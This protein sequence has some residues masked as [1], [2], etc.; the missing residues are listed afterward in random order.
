MSPVSVVGSSTPRSARA[1]SWGTLTRPVRT[2]AD[3][4]LNEGDGWVTNQPAG[5]PYTAGNGPVWWV[6]VGAEDGRSPIGPNGPSP[7]AAITTLD[8]ATNVIVE[9]IVAAGWRLYRGSW[10]EGTAQALP[11]PVWITDPMLHGTMPGAVQA[12]TPATR[13][14]TASV[15][16]AQWV[17][18]AL[19][20]GTGWLI[21]AEAFDSS[22]LPGS[23][24]ILHPSMVAT[25]P[26]DPGRWRIGDDV[27]YAIT[28]TDGRLTAGNLTYRVVPLHGVGPV[29]DD[30][31]TTGV[32]TRH[33]ATLSLAR[34][35]RSY[36][37]GTFR[38]GV[39]AGYLKSQTALTQDQIDSLKQKWL[40]SHGGDR[41][42][43]AIL[44]S[45][46]DFTPISISPL[47]AQLAQMHQLTLLELAHAFNLAAWMLDAGSDSSTYANIQDRRQDHTD[48][49][50]VPWARRVAEALSGVLPFGTW[51]ELDFRAYLQTD[52][53][54]RISY[55]QSMHAM[56]AMT[57]EEIRR[58][59]RLGPLPIAQAGVS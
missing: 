41:R 21:F 27:N 30:G 29:D 6:G 59:E 37:S 19:W 55:Y 1:A 10:A 18:A 34:Q 23:L 42:S 50:L 56:G 35:V 31:N 17:R 4:L 5:Q 48:L 57:V 20:Y 49:T 54:R 25:D 52:E 45:T 51:V 11:T 12:M 33:G 39:P 36:A 13:R 40:A 26:D 15:F 3:L 53:R 47:D 16:W 9:P 43:I 2:N 58:L 22:P 44:N 8:R 28:D 24:R 32:L 38:S 46:T 14:L 7:A